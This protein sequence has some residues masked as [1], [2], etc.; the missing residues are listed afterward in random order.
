MNLLEPLWL[1]LSVAI[2]ATAIAFGLGLIAALSMAHYRGRWRALGDGIAI[3]PLVLPPSVVGFVLLFVLGKRGPL[4]WL[5]DS[6]RFS[7][8][9]TWYAAVIAASLVAFPLM[10]LTALG[11]IEQ[12]DPELQQAARTLGASEARVFWRVTL[13]LARSGIAAGTTLAFARA[14]GEFGATLMVAGNIPGRTQTLPMAI[15]VAVEAGDYR[16][17]GL[18]SLLA[19]VLS[20]TGIAIAHR[21]RFAPSSRLP[22][23]VGPEDLDSEWESISSPRL[24][25]EPSVSVSPSHTLSVDIRKQFADFS[26]DLTF[27]TRT[28]VLGILGASGAGKSALLRCIAGLEFPDTGRIAWGERCLFD[29][30]QDLNI[31]SHQRHIGLMFQN[32]ALFPHLNVADNVA[33]GLSA[34]SSETEE[35][36]RQLEAVQMS[37]YARRYPEQLSGGQ[38]QRVAL[39]RTLASQP[40]LLLLDEPFSAL[41]THL[42]DRLSTQLVN[43]L[44]SF[45]GTTLLVTHNVNE[46]YR[47]C[48]ELLVIDRGRVIAFGPKRDIFERP[49]T[50]AVARLTGCQNLSRAIACSSHSIKAI[51]WG[52][53]LQTVAV[54]P[55]SLQYVG[56]R[57]HHVAI[58]TASSADNTF[59]CWPTSVSELP[60]R[61]TMF[62]K[63]HAPPCHASDYHLQLETASTGRW[64][65]LQ[66]CP[67]P[68][69]VH[70]QPENLLLLHS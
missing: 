69:F 64:E 27:N 67:P 61:I 42:R 58:A 7:I 35:V 20:L 40:D 25:P 3:A 54:V 6:L 38:R 14:L 9:F 55:Q 41:D 43:R 26:L 60:Q 8:A 46:A 70:I 19:I 1:S 62:V 49:Q 36:N 22:Q 28:R 57:S 34:S 45:R 11:A 47:L 37:A 4:G 50:L 10:Y 68:W 59:P 63:L 16:Q 65:N 39:A 29:S 31:P 30:Q 53:T 24:L 18:G 13:P 15:Y 51:D 32:Y 23:Q 21:W 48:D 5:F 44:Q 17:A 52:C 66:R 12:I 33:F 2:A 56:I